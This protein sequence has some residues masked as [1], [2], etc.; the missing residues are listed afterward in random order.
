VDDT[1]PAMVDDALYVGPVSGNRK[2][3]KNSGHVSF[4]VKKL[5]F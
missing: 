1:S 5:D 4:L 3:I 2:V